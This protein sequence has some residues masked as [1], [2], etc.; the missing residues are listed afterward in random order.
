MDA[1]T[2]GIIANTA[3]ILT[4][5][6]GFLLFIYYQCSK[7]QKR[8]RVERHL[9]ERAV[10]TRSANMLN[11]LHEGCSVEQ[12]VAALNMSETDVLA[13]LPSIKNLELTPFGPEG[14]LS[15]RLRARYVGSLPGDKK[16]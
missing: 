13:V 7:A 5:T 3:S 11:T 16:N 6:G 14:P 15:M 2:F 12:I 4:A 10:A 1:N 8:Q 9:K